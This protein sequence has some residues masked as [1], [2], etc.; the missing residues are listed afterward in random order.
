[1]YASFPTLLRNNP[2]SEFPKTT[3]DNNEV[4]MKWNPGFTLSATAR[5]SAAAMVLSLFAC[6]GSSNKPEPT[7]PDE[8]TPQNGWELVW[9]D[10]F[11][12]DQ[13][14]TSKWSHEVNCAGGGN[15]ELQCY[16]ERSE[17]SYVED[18][19]LY[20]VARE[21]SYSG[22]GVFDDDPAYDPDDQSV[23]RDYTS[24]RLRT[25]NLGDWRYG[26]IEVTAKMPEGQG[27]WPAIWMMPTDSV[28]GGWPRS[29]EIDIFEAVNTNASG[30]NEIHGTLHYGR[31]WPDNQY[32]GAAFVPEEPIWEDFHTYAVEWEE[33]EIRWYFND[34][35]FA[36]QTQDGWF[37]YTWNGQEEGFQMGPGAAPF[38]QDFHLIINV[39]VGGNWPGSPNAE[40]QFPQ[41]MVVDSVRVYQC[42]EDPSTGKGC[43]TV[44]PDVD[45]LTGNPAPEVNAFS[46]YE[47]GPAVLTHEVGDQEVTNALVPAYYEAS[48]GNVTADPDALHDGETVW[49]IQ[50]NGPGNVFLMSGSMEDTPELEDGLRFT[51]MSVY[52]ELRFDLFVESIDEDT[53]LLVKLDSGW[54]NVSYHAIDVPETG[55][56]TSVSVRISDLLPNDIEP[57]EVDLNRV[58]N[59]FVIEPEGGL[60]HIKLNNIHVR[61][62][63]D[64]ALDPVPVGVSSVLDE[65][66]AV[67][68]D[69]EPGVN[70]D[71]GVGSWDNDSGH[72]SVDVVEDSDRGPVL[73]VAF[74]SAD[75]NG[76]AFIQATSGKDLTA[77]AE[78]GQLVFDLQ[79]VDYGTNTS[80]L[81]VKAESGPATG[82]GDYI[83][84]PAPPVGEWVEVV[85]DVAD[86]LQHPGTA[87]NFA[88]DSV[89]TPFVILPVWDDQH[90]VRLR[91]DNI[92]WV[93]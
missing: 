90:G 93:R 20:L 38:D 26:R 14:D 29:G 30:G 89:N 57:G 51:N 75:H 42:S 52:G 50:F 86:M 35:H 92:Y 13:I 78:D 31:L 53:Q 62:L 64:C 23:Q 54:P 59:V 18:G 65:T 3:N 79:V 70:W 11:E 55:E 34:Q 88:L 69:G 45:P 7:D 5:L 40:T 19:R 83:I 48:P 1:M 27:I 80:G 74:N 25:K 16:T 9:S 6:G 28:Y 49:D 71:F 17:N 46:L 2:V 15:N 32:S 68:E 87:D 8:E 37:T 84:T 73:E 63:A 22:P 12:G 82:T 60:A 72:V 58:L 81:V 24:A 43:A 85:I 47:N 91:L 10:D 66:F 61:C 67:F 36:T 4:L 39:A 56:W 77:F 76:L 41:Q 44:D 33:G 21:E